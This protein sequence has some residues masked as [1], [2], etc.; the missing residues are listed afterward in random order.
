MSAEEIFD[1]CDEQDRVISTAPRSV[2]HAR[3]LLHRAV[4]I[5]VFNTRGELLFHRR[6]AAKDE[7]PLKLTSSA[8]GHLGTGEDYGPAA[9]RELE[10]ELGLRGRLEYV[11][12]LPASP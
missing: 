8:S 1:V 4:H 3:R 9:D 5:F 10:E 6:S 7:S 2:V 11:T 12:K